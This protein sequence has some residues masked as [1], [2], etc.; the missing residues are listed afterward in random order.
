MKN[1][2]RFCVVALL[3][4]PW[5]LRAQQH[6][7][8]LLVTFDYPHP[9][10]NLTYVT[11]ISNTGATVGYFSVT[12]TTAFVRSTKGTFSSPITVHNQAVF[13]GGINTS[14]LVCGYTVAGP[15]A[16][17][18]HGFFFQNKILTTYDVPGA[19]QT[20]L[21]S[22]NDEGNFV[23]AYSV[24]NLF[25]TIGFTSIGGTIAEIDIPDSTIV[26]PAGINNSNEVVGIYGTAENINA[27]G[28]YQD[29]NGVVITSLNYPGAGQTFLTGI[30]DQG[31]IVG[32]YP[33]AFGGTH[34]LLLESL[35]K[36]STLD[37]PGSTSTEINAIN[38]AGLV[39][40]TCSFPDDSSTGFI[41]R[42]R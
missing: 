24:T 30:N 20:D 29:A 22:L 10:E 35:T 34:G 26:L 21:F 13:S 36:F 32:Y 1:A 14:G 16:L 6:T 28:F 33:R 17:T 41:A 39:A 7:L 4:M 37:V 5:V 42:I 18:N 23:G 11:G 38:N 19:T 12:H 8:E 9:P 3:M 2:V 31:T 27:Q 15:P 40:G 25:P